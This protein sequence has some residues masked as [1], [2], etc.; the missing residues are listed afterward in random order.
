MAVQNLKRCR[1]GYECGRR[2]HSDS[3]ERKTKSGRYGGRG[4]THGQE[5]DVVARC[6]TIDPIDMTS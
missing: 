6:E 2:R 4:G 3:K 5:D 1:A